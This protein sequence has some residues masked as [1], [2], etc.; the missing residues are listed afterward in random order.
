MRKKLLAL[1]LTLCMVL[2]LLPV[3]AMAVEG[4]VSQETGY[5]NA[6]LPAAPAVTGDVI[7]VTPENAQYT[8]DGAYGSID[9]KTICFSGGDYTDVLV[10]ARPTKFVGSNTEYYNGEWTSEKGWEPVKPN[11]DWEQLTSTIC[12]YN[13]KVE[14]VTFTAEEGV[15]LP[16][17]SYSSGH[18]YGQNGAPAYDHVRDMEIV[19]T[20]RSYH[21]Y[22]SL[23][24]ITFQGL[25]ISGQVFLQNYSG[26]QSME[27]VVS[28]ITFD[29][30][31]FTGDASKMDTAT[32]A[33]VKTGADSRYFTNITVKN[34]S[35]KNYYQGVY[36]QGVDGLTVEN[37]V[38]EN[39]RH[40]SIAVQSSTSNPVKGAVLIQENVLKNAQ[41]RA[42][43][44]GDMGSDVTSILINNN[45]MV[46]SG[47]TAGELIKAGTLPPGAISLENNYWDGKELSTAVQTFSVPKSTGIISGTF[48]IELDPAW[49]AEGYTVVRDGD[50]NYTVVNLSA[51]N[52][53]ARINEKYYATL[54]AATAAAKDGETVTL[55]ETTTD[56]PAIVVNNG[57]KITLD[58]AGHEIGFAENSYFIVENGALNVTGSGKIYEQV[59]YT[60]VITMVGS[61]ET[62]ASEYS[63]LT[64]GENVVLEGYSGVLLDKN[65]NNTSYGTV[66]TINGTIHG[67]KDAGGY[68]SPS[69]SVNGTINATEGNVPKITIASTAEI[70]SERGDSQNNNKAA[71]AGVYAAG[72]AE[73]EIEDGAKLS[74][75]DVLSIKS[76]KFTIKGGTFTA[77]GP[78]IDPAEAFNNGTEST[79]AAISI[80]NNNSY[81]RNVELTVEGG[82]FT[83]LNGYAL[84]ES[85]T[86]ANQGNALKVGGT[87]EV[88]GGAFSG[89]AGA[90]SSKHGEKFISGGHF[91]FNP[92]AYLAKDKMVAAST[93]KGYTYMVTNQVKVGETEVA[94]APDA[95]PAVDV[96]KIPEGSQIDVQTAIEN[97]TSSGLDAAAGSV[98]SDSNAVTKEMSET[99]LTKAKE[100]LQVTGTEGSGPAAADIKLV[101]Q[102]YME[103]KAESYSATE[104]EKTLQV[105]ITPKYNLLVVKA[106]TSVDA[107]LITNPGT[108]ETKN[109]AVVEEEKDL[110]VDRNTRVTIS[111]QLPK[112]FIS[113]TDAANLYVVHTKKDGTTET[114]K[115]TVTE[116]EQ[117]SATGTTEKIY[118]AT[119]TT[120]G[121][122][123]F[124][125]KVDERTAS[126][127]FTDKDGG[128]LD[129]AVTYTPADVGKAL[130]EAEAPSGQKFRGW[131]FTALGDTVYQTLT[132]ALLSELNALRLSGTS[133]TATPVF[134]TPSSGGGSMAYDVIVPADPENGIITV[135]DTS[136][137]PGSTVTITVKP[138][139]GYALSGLTV[140]AQD[141]SELSLSDL[142]NGRY[143]FTMPESPVAI[144][145]SFGKA[146]EL[147]F[148]DVAANAWYHEAVQY[149]YENGMMLGTGETSFSPETKLTRG[150]AVTILHRLE[151]EPAAAPNP[152][153]D[154]ADSAYYNEAIAWGAENGIVNGFGNNIFRPDSSITREEFAAIL[155]RYA[156]YKGMED[157][158]S[159]D[160]SAFTDG[161]KV[162]SWAVEYMRWAVGNR[163]INGN[164]DGTLRPAGTATRAEAAQ[165][166]K[167]MLAK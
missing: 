101:V 61:N 95:A 96:T 165:M 50:G 88:L 128:A 122:S 125:F 76:G 36:I 112:G 78:F 19:D 65:G 60:A 80:T 22:S 121:F 159:G 102:P 142:G 127:Q 46:G 154:V 25:T 32:F 119:F 71:S 59:P 156:Q 52:A 137:S 139:E 83:S 118:I 14:N 123:P 98:A 145:V 43:R 133:I 109:A 89:K 42:I 141:G 148:A 157:S 100:E 30:C 130:P 162:G 47:D 57:R 51:D 110:P 87:F 69:I 9:G 33:A 90:V 55:L 66:V 39:T 64:V 54:A 81:A 134:Y 126:V 24:N 164:G 105:E 68:G 108:G 129:S 91:T 13:R 63:V 20:N 143:A 163:V 93:E 58:L 155:C 158:G 132:E 124:L 18:V 28:G 115:P 167:N 79:G 37:C 67:K 152:F 104:A 15:V 136:A 92:G 103:I 97:A 48:F 106:E 3:T 120:N 6:A 147:P 8:L 10:L 99:A 27:A 72:Y 74:G 84:Y 85:D 94:P 34:C 38:I 12:Y 150:M 138:D 1:L 53:A 21:A 11:I 153:T 140:T 73:W 113:G 146:G 161:D 29:G 44:F 160:L 149:V 166:L 17:F 135:S 2:S 86:A 77:D 26:N 107:P 16:G 114:Y 131:K 70:T 49:C 40:N 7:T 62:S 45:V 41:D 56:N 116:A 23:K 35:I 117:E 5:G 4:N 31:T 75:N 144:G 111:F 82:T 151:K